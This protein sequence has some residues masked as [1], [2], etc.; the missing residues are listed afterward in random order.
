MKYKGLAKDTGLFAISTFAS[1][2]LVFFLTPLYTS[3][4]STEEYG[5]ADLVTTII[6]TIYPILTLSISE[7]TLRFAL[8]K[9]ISKNE[10]LCTSI[11]F[12]G[13]SNILILFFYP[14]IL[15]LNEALVT[16]WW[17]FVITYIVFNI[18]NCFS[19]FIK[20]T[21]K[22]KLYAIQGIIQTIVI[23]ICNILFLIV[24]KIGLRGY[25][26]SIILG[27]T[28]PFILMFFVGKIYLNLHPFRLNRNL[29]K[30]MLRYSIPM[31]P[32]LLAW[33]INTS[34]DKY[35]ITSMIGLSENGLYS[36]AHK[37][38]TILTTVLSV[39]IQAWQIYAISNYQNPEASKNYSEIYNILNI[40]SIFACLGII[41]LS[42]PLAILLYAKSFFSAW[43]F[44]PLLTISAM[45][46]S[47]SGFLAAT[48]R[49]AKKTKSLFVSVIVG[50]LINIVL[51]FI[52]LRSLGTIG[53]AISTSVSFFVVWLIRFLL[54][55]K[56][57][58]IVIPKFRTVATYILLFVMAILYMWELS[59]TLIGACIC[60]CIILV[61]NFKEILKVCCYIRSTIKG[62]KRKK[63]E[64]GENDNI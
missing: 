51:N 40:F 34:I 22:T 1:K 52:L 25:L 55:Q 59:I 49:A 36:A 7:A 16:Y 30:E 53:A 3:V 61:M 23:I 4:L 60:A 54:A 29:I 44:V 12:I 10:V 5:I 24:F 31:I 20:G 39:F 33:S 27:Y 2:L 46:S 37:I 63:G 13:I 15:A 42:K 48:Y 35:M 43:K 19:N 38:P 28:I 56:M 21:E 18:Q 41:I 14:L 50:A 64:K 47:L 58:K 32:A 17:Y 9:D 8:E 6:N 45:F 57:V 11:L 62:K 26:I